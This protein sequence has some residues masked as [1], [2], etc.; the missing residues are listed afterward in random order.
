M[1]TESLKSPRLPF[2]SYIG[3]PLAVPHLAA[4]RAILCLSWLAVSALIIGPPAVHGQTLAQALNATNLTWTTS[5]TSGS[6]GWSAETST[7][8]DGVSAADSGQVYTPSSTSTLRTTVNGPGTLTFWWTNPSLNNQLSFSVNG[9]NL[10]NIMLY[11]SWQQQT[12]Y[13]GSGSQTSKWVYAVSSI[14]ADTAH[15][16]VDQVSWTPGAT[17]PLITSQPTG[18]SQVPGLDTTFTVV[19][20]GTPPLYYQWQFGGSDIPG[21]TAS[22]YTVTN[23]QSTNLGVYSVVVTNSVGSIVSSNAPLVFGQVAA[24]GSP[25]QGATATPAGATNVLAIAAGNYFNLWLSTEGTV[26]GWGW[27][28]NGVT[29]YPAN[30]T[31][32]IAI[33]AG[34]AHCLALTSDGTV[35]AWGG[36]NFGETNVPAGLSNVVAIAGG[37]SPYSVALRAD[38]T[39]AAWGW[40]HLGETNVPADLTSVV[41]LA[42]GYGQI[43]ALKGDGILTNWGSFAPAVPAG[44]TN[45]VAVAAGQGH[46]LALLADGTVVAWGQNSYGQASVPSGLT[47]AVAIAA[48]IS[49]SMALL[50]NGTVIAWGYNASGATNVP[51]ALTNVVAISAGNYHNLARVGSGP[52]IPGTPVT[53]PSRSANGFSLVVPSQSG[54]VYALEYKD[55]LSDANWASLP[56]TAGTGKDL[57]LLDPTANDSQRFYR[58]RRW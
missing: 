13:L 38:G 36:Q 15:S 34:S 46:D 22:A 16:Y 20:G 17:A 28:V 27:D 21:A 2:A 7:T 1:K 47:N 58:V 25:F 19:A 51:S 40:N 44:L 3:L 8:H 33:A 53:H 43:I 23:V 32:A 14:P 24:W 5:G 12:F 42:A 9:A 56:L 52:P 18:Q 35:T 26:C 39:V 29:N 6:F 45:V 41:A 30:L 50:A 31:N 11:H 10:A 49:H 48:G 55:N 54:R 57:V 4:S 37:L